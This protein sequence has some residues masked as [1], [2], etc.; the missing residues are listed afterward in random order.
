MDIKGSWCP[1]SDK[2]RILKMELA[3]VAG[4]IT[5]IWNLKLNFKHASL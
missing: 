2:V 1:F 3:T 4:G 5:G